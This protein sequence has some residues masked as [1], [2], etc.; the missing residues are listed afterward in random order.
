MLSISPAPSPPSL[1]CVDDDGTVFDEGDEMPDDDPCNT[2]HCDSGEKI[3][4]TVECDLPDCELGY[5]IV[6][7]TDKC[8]ASCE[9]SK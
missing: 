9:E 1:Q 3:C 6:Y 7:I 5:E 4:E 8:C 2:C